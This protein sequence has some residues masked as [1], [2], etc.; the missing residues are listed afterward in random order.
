LDDLIDVGVVT[1]V[2]LVVLVEDLVARPDHDGGAQLHGPSTG[3]LLA[4]A[5]VL[6]GRVF[7]RPNTTTPLPDG[8]NPVVHHVPKAESPITLDGA[9]DEPAWE[10]AVQFDL[11]YEVRPGDSIPPP[12]RTTCMVTYTERF[13]YFGFRA[14]DPDPARIRARY[15]DRDTAWDDDWVGVVLDTF[16][17]QRRAYELFSTPLGVQI[18]AINDDVQRRYDTSWDAIW[19]SGGRLTDFGNEPDDAQSLVRLL[20]YANEIDI[21]G[22]LATTSMWL[23]GEVQVDGVRE[24]V[25]AYARVRDGEVFVHNLHISP[26]AKGNRENVDPVRTRK[27]L[28]RAREIRKLAKSTE[29]TGLTIVATR[30]YLKDGWIKIELAV[31]KGKKLYDKR[32]SKRTREVEREMARARGA[33]EA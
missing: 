31:A 15:S 19:Y 24:H 32:E 17:D 5:L 16:N 9:L 20:V 14:F 13:I 22:I 3:V 2:V 33:R 12:V 4:I 8:T 27:L 23:R 11:E 10:S 21:E 1:C 29:T 18:D 7:P 26:Y 30:M 28:L 6:P 25:E